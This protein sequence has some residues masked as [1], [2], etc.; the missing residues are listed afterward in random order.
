MMSTMTKGTPYPTIRTLL[1][2]SPGLL[3]LIDLN[4]VNYSASKVCLLLPDL[5][6]GIE[7]YN[8][9]PDKCRQEKVVI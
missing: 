6:E 4:D 5:S 7:A 1:R 2:L 3:R 8:C 9:H